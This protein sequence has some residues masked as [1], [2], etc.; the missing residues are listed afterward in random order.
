MSATI[1]GHTGFLV[2]AMTVSRHSSLVTALVA[3]LWL[4]APALAQEKYPSRPIRLIVPYP[5]GGSTDPAGRLFAA[6]LSD[7]FKQQVVVDNRPGAGATIG[8]GLGAKAT[9]DGY[10]I[11]LGTSGGLATAPALGSKISYDPVRDFAPIGLGVYAP[12]LLVV[13]PA[14]PAK[15]VKEFVAYGKAAGSS[16]SFAS[17]GVGTPNHLGAELLKSMTGFQFVHVPYKGGAPAILDVMAGRAQALFGGIPYTGPHAKTGKVRA[18][19]IG[20]PARMAT[21]PDVPAVAETLP[22]FTNTTWYGLLAPAGT[23]KAVVERINAEM[24]KAVANP[25][26]VKQLDAIGLEP[27]S[28]SAAEFQEMIRS[29]LKRWSKVIKEAGITAETAQ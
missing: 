9:P 19:A 22:G 11:L 15:S 7:A 18:I 2:S 4:I 16:I 10:T 28:S 26:F 5:P 12:F 3:A 17:P 1:F 24:R 21:W 8:H 14:V 29:E 6:W 13:H 27:A 25:E 20:H 23:P